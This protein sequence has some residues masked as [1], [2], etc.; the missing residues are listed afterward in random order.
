[1]AQQPV[2]HEAY[3]SMLQHGVV[4]ARGLR[5]VSCVQEASVFLAELD[6]PEEYHDD[7][8]SSSSSES[9]SAAVPAADPDPASAFGS[10]PGEPEAP[11]DKA[12]V[13]PKLPWQVFVKPHATGRDQPTFAMLDAMSA[14][15]GRNRLVF[16]DF[17]Y[18]YNKNLKADYKAFLVVMDYKTRYAQVQ[19]LRSKEQTME[20]FGV[21]AMRSGW[22]KLPH[23]V[24]VVSDGEPKL[25]QQIAAA[26]QRLGLM[27]STSVPNRPNTNPAGSNLVRSLRRLVDC[28]LVD[29]SRWGSVINGTFEAIAWEFAVH[30]HNALANRSDPLNRSPHEL[31]FGV[32]PAFQQRAFG[33]PGYMHLTSNGRRAHIARCGLAGAHRAERVLYIG[34]R[35]G[36]HRGL[37]ERGTSRCGPMFVDLEGILGCSRRQC[38]LSSLFWQEGWARKMT[39]APVQCLQF[40]QVRLC[41]KR[42]VCC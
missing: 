16:C 29:G 32:P 13:F 24:H 19:P 18:P 26:C 1:M 37:T 14:E 25:V 17:V 9:D 8:N 39:A 22:H 42:L 10:D 6:E 2:M 27:H 21:V 5:H 4:D 7:E 38:L 23:G 33:T 11:V 15:D 36:H 35:D 34:E 40:L 31:K 12:V 20:A 30:T 3:L 28:A 41:A